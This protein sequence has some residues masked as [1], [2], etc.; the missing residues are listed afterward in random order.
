MTQSK[1]QGAR[2]ERITASPRW[3]GTRFR[4]T[5]IIPRGDP[6]VPMPAISEF[7]CGGDRRVP[8]A[9]LP[10]LNPLDAWTRKPDSGLRATWLGHST[11]LIEIDGW[12][13]LT[14]PV[15]GPRASPSR[16]LGP[17]RFQPVP[18]E[19]RELPP[20]DAVIVS[21]DHYDHLDYTTMRL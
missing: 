5:S 6:G 14:D 12:R 20:L 15:W 16:F 2:L 11:V 9:A 21:H 7:L 13:V 10:A 3:D 4:N 18:V 19:V 1:T 17:K 8:Q